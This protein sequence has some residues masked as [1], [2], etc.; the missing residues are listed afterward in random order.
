M[1]RSLS[2]KKSV[3]RQVKKYYTDTWIGLLNLRAGLYWG[4]NAAFLLQLG[5]AS[6][7][8]FTKNPQ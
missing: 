6:V 7:S 8:T 3:F 1:L 2:A 5:D 4:G